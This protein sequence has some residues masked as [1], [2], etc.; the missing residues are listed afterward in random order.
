MGGGSALNDR[1][2]GDSRAPDDGGNSGCGGCGGCGT[3]CDMTGLASAAATNQRLR[4]L[5]AAEARP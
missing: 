3:I 4:A 2:R 1:E 5:A